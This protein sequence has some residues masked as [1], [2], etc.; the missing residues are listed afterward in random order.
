MNKVIAIVG[1]TGSKKSR[2]A[3]KLITDLKMNTELISADAFQVYKDLNIGTNKPD[4]QQLQSVKHHFV[5]FLEINEKWDIFKFQLQAKKILNN[6]WNK[7]QIPIVCGGSHLYVDALLKDYQLLKSPQRQRNNK[8]LLSNEELYS[9]LLKIDAKEALK[10]GSN[11]RRRLIRAIEIFENTNQPKS[12]LDNQSVFKYETCLIVCLPPRELLYASLNLRTVK[13]YQNG[14][15]QEI[16]QLFKKYPNLLELQ[17]I[18]AI[19]YYYLA[20][21]LHTNAE[22]ELA[23]LQQLVRNLAKRQI[24]WCKNRY[25]KIGFIYDETDVTWE[26][27]LAYVR[28]FLKD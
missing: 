2:I 26:Q 28:N 23:K 18:K 19:G 6:L 15:I 11:N 21:C 24:T 20:N 25:C 17:S 3:L 7:N 8:D 22:P 1:P 9:N 5:D 16:Q 12:T 14:W 27:L 13:M 10:I 4:H